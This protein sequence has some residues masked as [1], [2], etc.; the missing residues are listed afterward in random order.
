MGYMKIPNLY[1]DMR[2]FNLKECYAMEKVHGTSARIVWNNNEIQYVSGGMNHKTFCDIFNHED[3]LEKFDKEFKDVKVVI[4]G[5]AYG[6]KEQ[7]MSGTYGKEPSFIVF[8]VKIGDTWLNVPNAEDISNK[9]GLE[10]VPYNKV[11]TDLEVLNSQRDLPS[12]VASRRGMGEDKMREGIVI[13]PL[14]ELYDNKGERIIV[15]HKRDEF[16]ETKN[17]REVDPK[18]LKILTEANEIAEEWVT[19]M[20]FSHVLDKFNYDK[21]IKNTGRFG[22]AMVEDVLLESEGEI[23][24]SSEAKKAIAKKACNMYIDYI[25]KGD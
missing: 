2:I 4:F 17:K 9:L 19:P 22:S 13:K 7:G 12:V 24:I 20:R 10:F 11:S 15:K 21:D 16:R 14:E 23:I 3:L 18:K 8:E 25:K 1:K 6:G 5:E